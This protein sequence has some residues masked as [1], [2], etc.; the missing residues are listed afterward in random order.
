MV[1]IIPTRD[2]EGM[3]G[4]GVTSDTDEE[5]MGAVVKVVMLKSLI[6]SQ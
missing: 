5:E 6:K 3:L 1:L 2:E 4:L